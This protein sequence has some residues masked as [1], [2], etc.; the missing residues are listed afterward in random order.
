MPAD[1][2]GSVPSSAWETQW[3]KSFPFARQFELHRF[4]WNPE[5]AGFQKTWSERRHSSR[6]HADARAALVLL[7]EFM[8]IGY[9]WTTEIWDSA[10]SVELSARLFDG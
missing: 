4:K 9:V 2:R 7:P 3:I 8:S 1:A 6:R 5:T 10:K